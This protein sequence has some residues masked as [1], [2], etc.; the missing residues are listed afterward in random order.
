MTNYRILGKLK[1]PCFSILAILSI[2]SSNGDVFSFSLIPG[3][4]PMVTATVYCLGWPL[5]WLIIISYSMLCIWGLYKVSLHIK[6]FAIA[7]T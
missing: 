2:V 5:K 6:L 3:A 7:V 4:L 1:R